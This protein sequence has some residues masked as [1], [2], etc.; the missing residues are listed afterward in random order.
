MPRVK[1]GT[2]HSK[3]R[4]TLLKQAKG[5]KWGRKKLI[6]SAKTAVVKAGANA[7]NGRKEKKQVNRRLWQV[8][9]NAA[10]RANDTTYSKFI[11]M[12]KKNKV[13]TDRKVLSEL[14]QK[15][16]KAFDKLVAEVKK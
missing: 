12:L 14:A 13:E 1:R 16:P 9:I 3:K 2:Q 15:A 7:Y 10:V 5:Y 11:D 6:K 4:K 8:K